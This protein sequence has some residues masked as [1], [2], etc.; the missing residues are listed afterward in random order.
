MTVGDGVIGVKIGEDGMG[1]V[2]VLIVVTVEVSA[3]LA[4]AARRDVH[5]EGRLVH[6]HS[7][8]GGVALVVDVVVFEVPVSDES[9][10]DGELGVGEL[11]VDEVGEPYEEKKQEGCFF[12]G[13]SVVAPFSQ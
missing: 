2:N 13:T 9:V 7:V 12:H 8:E 5:G 11:G 4:V 10:G 1:D 3:A 6:W